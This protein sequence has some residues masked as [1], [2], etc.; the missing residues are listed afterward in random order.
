MVGRIPPARML[1][2]INAYV[3]ALLD[4][5]LKGERNP[6]L[7]GPSSDYPEASITATVGR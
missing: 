1:A 3:L 6:L 2:I 4:R 5:H 7:N